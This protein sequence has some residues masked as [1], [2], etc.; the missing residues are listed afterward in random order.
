MQHEPHLK[1]EWISFAPDGKADSASYFKP[2]KL[3]FK[4]ANN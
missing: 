3:A 2:I 4:S 1:P